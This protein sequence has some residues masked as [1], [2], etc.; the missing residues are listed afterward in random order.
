M[1]AINRTVSALYLGHTI[2]VTNHWRRGAS[3]VIDCV[4]RATTRELLALNRNKPKLTTQLEANGELHRVE[5]YVWAPFL[6]V[7]LK[8]CVNGKRIGGDEF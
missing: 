2:D 6:K 1:G 5:V 7:H 8:I 3:L 4:T